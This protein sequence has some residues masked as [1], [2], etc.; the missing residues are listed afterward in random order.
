MS[1]LITREMNGG[2]G[3]SARTAKIL[4]HIK[5]TKH[6]DIMQDLAVYIEML[7]R[8]RFAAMLG[9][10]AHKHTSQRGFQIFKSLMYSYQK[11]SENRTLSTS[12]CKTI[13]AYC[14]LGRTL[15]CR[16]YTHGFE[17]SLLMRLVVEEPIG[18]GHAVKCLVA[19]G[20]LPNIAGQDV[21]FI[22]SSVHAIVVQNADI[23]LNSRVV[24]RANDASRG[25]AFSG[26]VE[27]DVFSFV[28]DTADA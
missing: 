3:Y 5:E 13:E 21:C 8:S 19:F 14:K 15:L 2:D 23:E 7:R 12:K 4:C 16:C 24:V 6:A 26:N 20:A 9:I 28:I 25:G 27:I 22:L 10:K 1:T 11:I 18:E 17:H